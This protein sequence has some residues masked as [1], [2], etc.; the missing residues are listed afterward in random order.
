M[1][2]MSTNEYKIKAEHTPRPGERK[3]WVVGLYQEGKRVQ[4]LTRN[5]SQKEGEGMVGACA[6]AVEC[7]ARMIGILTQDLA[8]GL[9]CKG[10]E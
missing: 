8:R 1:Q 6:L 7:G 4:V 3:G 2:G 9:I 10:G 5:R